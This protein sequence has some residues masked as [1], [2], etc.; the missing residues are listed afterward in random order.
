LRSDSNGQQAVSIDP[1]L[2]NN[3]TS[4]IAFARTDLGAFGSA[5][6]QVDRMSGSE[7][8]RVVAPDMTNSLENAEFPAY[9][10]NIR[11]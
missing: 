3:A 1:Q 11:P 8:G 10:W 6:A 9:G 4:R 5:S 2:K 7:H